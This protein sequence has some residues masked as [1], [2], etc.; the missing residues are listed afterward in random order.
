ML[1]QVGAQQLVGHGA[2]ADVYVYVYSLMHMVLP[3]TCVWLG[4][5]CCGRCSTMCG[6]ATAAL[7]SFREPR[8]RHL[9]DMLL[10]QH[11]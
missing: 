6:F 8:N 4:V 5:L 1:K 7:L 3:L 2:A 11:C 9:G 10:Q